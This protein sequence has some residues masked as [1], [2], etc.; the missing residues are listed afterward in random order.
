MKFLFDDESFSFETLRAAGFTA[1]QGADLGEILATAR[2]IDDGD[3][4]SWHRSWK[5]TAERVAAIGRQA[6]AA[7]HRVSAREAL[8]RASNYYRTAEF[9][10]RSAPATDPEV[11]LLS[12]ASRS[13]FAAA[14]ALFDSPVESVAIPYEDTTLPGYLFLVDDSGTAR[15][16]VVYTNG[17]D[18][19][20][21]EAY[22]VIA[23]AALRRGYNVLAFDGPGQGAVL[24]EQKLVFRPDWEA[25]STPVVDYAL[26]RPEIDPVRITLFGYS[27]GGYLVARAAAHDHRVAALI[28]DDGVLDFGG[29]FD[30]AL[31]P[32]VI[33]WIAEGRDEAAEAALA[34]AAAENTQV[35]W[36]LDNGVWTVGAHSYADL[37]RRSRAYSLEGSAD[38]I[39]APT[40]VL[41][42]E[43]DQFFKGQP[44]LLADRL[45]NAPA[46]LVT[47]S[48]AEGAGEHCHVGAFHR[49]HQVMFDWLDT[50]LPSA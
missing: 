13:T 49:A 40:L 37:V 5:A 25:V 18:S 35:R 11:A 45:V 22:F 6:L 36:A 28:L 43:N 10:L 4:P 47:L 30:R 48:E 44:R 8:L 39:V 23:A 38:K 1:Y 14:A 26:T 32:E 42:A 7:G 41:D 3:E 17:Y 16:T 20:A 50:A 15:P 27:L 19:T 2:T 34:A 9:Y 29:V 46:T 31:P 33:A 12:S 21:E 24:R